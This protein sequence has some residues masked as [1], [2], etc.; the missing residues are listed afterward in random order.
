LIQAVYLFYRIIILGDSM[1]VKRSREEKR[2]ERLCGSVSEKTG[3]GE[4]IG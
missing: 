4:Y 3:C 1:G 2:Y